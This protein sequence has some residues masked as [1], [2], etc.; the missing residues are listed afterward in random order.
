MSHT[1]EV[2][3]STSLCVLVTPQAIKRMMF[4]LHQ[5][6]LDL[7]NC[8]SA[9]SGVMFKDGDSRLRLKEQLNVWS[10]VTIVVYF[11]HVLWKFKT[12]IV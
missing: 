4:A 10:C 8:D 11:L 2:G 6:S 1:L 9:A 5:G 7:P 12:N 3:Q